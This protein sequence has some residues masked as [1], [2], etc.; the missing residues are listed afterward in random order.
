[1]S[2]FRRAVLLGSSQLV[3]VLVTL[4]SRVVLTRLLGTA[5]FGE[6]GLALNN[7]TVLSRVLS[8]GI[9]PGSQHLASRKDLDRKQVIG[10]SLLV[11]LLMG[12]AAWVAVWAGSPFLRDTLFFRDQP[13]PEAWRMFLAMRDWLPVVMVAAN[14]AVT[15]IPLGK[16]RPYAVF[17]GLAG[18]PLILI[19]LALVAAN[20]GAMD[21]VVWAQVGTWVWLLGYVFWHLRGEFGGVDLDLAKRLFGY[22]VRAWPNVIL[23][24]GVARLATIFGAGFMGKVDLSIFVLGLNIVEATLAPYSMVGQLVLSRASDGTDPDGKSTL[25]LMRLSQVMLIAVLVLVAGLGPF[26]IPLL[27]GADF[28]AAYGV[29]LVLL[30]TGFAHSQ[31]RTLANFFAGKGKP[32]MA[33]PGLATELVVLLALV[34]ALGPTMGMQGLVIASIAGALLGTLVSSLQM[35]RLTASKWSEQFLLTG[36]DLRLL[37]KS[38][39]SL[40]KAR[41]Q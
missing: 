29:S 26:L 35:R 19:S 6:F 5:S 38:L 15:L 16:I 1:M 11:G 13:H 33:T 27:F 10:T 40:R 34:F 18:V 24:V 41:G 7:I 3:S 31:M 21:A 39:R 12:G 25:Q 23:G 17:Q 9:M 37:G 20:L 8:M 2:F 36:D 22:G 14:L 32:E 30:I 28:R 4:V